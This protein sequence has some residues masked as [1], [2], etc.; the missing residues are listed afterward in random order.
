MFS[1]IC[2]VLVKSLGPIPLCNVVQMFFS[3]GVCRELSWS[4][5][6][7][8]MVGRCSR[9]VRTDTHAWIFWGLRL[10]GEGDGVVVRLVVQFDTMGAWGNH[11]LF[12]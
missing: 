11:R 4:C 9:V 8:Q 6:W 10:I 5:R 1:S 3:D 12:H 7:V 2:S